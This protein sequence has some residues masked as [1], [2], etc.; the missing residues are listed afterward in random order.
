LDNYDRRSQRFET[1]HVFR[2]DAQTSM[3]VKPC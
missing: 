2:A 3:E 1:E